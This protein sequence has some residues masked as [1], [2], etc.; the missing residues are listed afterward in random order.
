MVPMISQALLLALIFLAATAGLMFLIRSM[1]KLSLRVQ[2]MVLL[3]L[4]VS[5]GFLFMTI[6]QVPGFSVWLGISLIAVVFIASLFGVR[7]F[8]HSLAEDK[9]EGMG[10]IHKYDP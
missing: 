1:R 9:A 3:A 6:V 8:L 10:D 5:I 7:I 2:F 4:G